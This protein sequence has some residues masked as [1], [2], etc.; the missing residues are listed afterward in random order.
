MSTTESPS[1]AE[2]VAG[3]RAGLADQLPPDVA[4]IF[5]TEQAHL[6]QSGIP[7]D[8]AEVGT[9]LPD[10]AL[11]DAQ[12]NPTSIADQRHGRPA[13]VVFYRGEWC[14][15][16]NL[17]LRAY[18]EQLLPTLAGRGI[19]LI[20]ISPEKPDNSLTMT[21]KNEL[22]FTVLSDPGNQ[23][24]SKLGILTA[25]TEDARAAQISLGV[26]LAKRNADGTY[27]VPMPT[28]LIVDAE[29]VIRWIDVHPNYATRTET[30]QIL[31]ALGTV[32]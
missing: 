22:A 31:A 4:A 23:M 14:P 10:G 25:P 29:G 28:V 13:V 15:Y 20:A 7:A 30:A 26:D 32:G 16:C 17:A 6:Q 18:Q 21:E 1:I 24:A 8:V 3:L 5:A 12:A 11:L 27:G 2:R 19:E 9:A